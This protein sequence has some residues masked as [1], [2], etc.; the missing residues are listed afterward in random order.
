METSL[1]ERKFLYALL[2]IVIVI[3]LAIFYP[4]LTVFFLAGAFSVFLRP[5]YLWIKKHITRGYEG[6]A[7]LVTIILFF[8]LLCT[9]LYFM[10]AIIFNQAQDAYYSIA[11]GSD[12]TNTFIQTIDTSINDFLPNGITFNTY[13]RITQLISFLTNNIAGF[14]SSTFHTVLMFIITIFTT[15]YLLKDGGKWKKNLIKIS[16]ISEKHIEKII[17][18]LK[19]AVNRIFK[20]T[21]LIAIIQGLLSWLGLTIFGVPNPALWGVVAGLASLIPSVGTSVVSIP[22]ILFLYFSGMHLQAL[23]LLLWSM[24]LV[25]MIDN[26]LAPYLISKDSNISPLFM[27]F[28]ILG[29]ISLMG[30][31]GIIIGPLVLSLFYSLISIYKKETI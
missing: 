24:L 20:G 1:I 9:P 25:G 3:V 16:P 4:F 31:T 28:S 27:M 6:L 23:G 15:F 12:S 26:L 19:N 10:G 8:V 22:A 13:E 14:F 5:I 29:G 11:Y 21:F 17:S 18:D 2:A 7:S 30:A